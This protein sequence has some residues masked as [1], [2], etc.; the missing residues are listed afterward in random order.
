MTRFTSL[1]SASFLL[2]AACGGGGPSRPKPLKTTFDESF[3]DAIAY[4]KKEPLFK[5]QNDFQRARAKFREAESQLAEAR[6]MVN[7]AKNER[8]KAI[9]DEKSA[10]E[11]KKTAESSNDMNKINPAN[12]DHRVAE[13][14]RRA[15]DEKVAARE[16]EVKYLKYFTLYAEEE[17]YHQEARLQLERAKAARANNIQPKGFKYDPFEEQVRDRSKRAQRAKLLADREKQKADAKKAKWNQAQN[18]VN[19]AEGTTNTADEEN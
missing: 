12:K 3:L 9:L 16:A 1:V 10:K 15:A 13:L 7:V 17:M 5:T 6:T 8:K 2:A 18:Q 19:A 4:E 11:Q 14:A